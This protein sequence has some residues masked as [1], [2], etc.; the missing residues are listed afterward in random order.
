MLLGGFL[1]IGHSAVFFD[2][3]WYHMDEHVTWGRYNEVEDQDSSG[4]SSYNF[5]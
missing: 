3:V 5:R 1:E 4:V 2:G